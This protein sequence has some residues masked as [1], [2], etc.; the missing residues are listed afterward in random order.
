VAEDAPPARPSSAG[1]AAE[2]RQLADLRAEGILS[3]EEYEVQKGRLLGD[4]PDAGA[5]EG[6]GDADSRPRLARPWLAVCG[7]V[8][9]VGVL[10]TAALVARQPAA[11]DTITIRGNFELVDSGVSGEID[12]CHG[13]DGFSDFGPGM[14]VTVK[15]SAGAIIGTASTRNA[16]I[17]VLSE[18][19]HA[20]DPVGGDQ[21]V[22]SLREYGDVT[23]VVIFDVEVEPSD[24]YAIEVGSRGELTYSAEELEA[25]DHAVALTLGT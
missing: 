13:T 7:L 2:I 14:N 25:A 4:A 6:P 20:A 10:A 9:L 16:G 24:F 5:E 17:E 19:I 12:D 21:S 15:D 22:A 3:P 1:I 18:Y 11:E 8:A 23:C